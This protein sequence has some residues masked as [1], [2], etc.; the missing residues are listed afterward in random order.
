MRGLSDKIVVSVLPY[1]VYLIIRFLEKTLRISY[2]NFEGIWKH[3]EE[4][5]K[6]IITFW[7]G[8]LLLMLIFL[9]RYSSGTT[10]LVSQHRDGELISRV[11]KRFNISS[12]RGSSTRGWLS[13][14]KGLLRE[15]KKGRDLAITPDGPK[16][17]RYIAQH[18]IINIAKN[19]GLP[20]FPM[21][22]SASKKKP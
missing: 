21:T 7:H 19:T 13:G 5:R 8:R 20:I 17:P 4:G 1:L 15:A 22:F 14:V 12:V 11:I 16:G 10:A 3:W 2:V 6:C 9:C 18:G